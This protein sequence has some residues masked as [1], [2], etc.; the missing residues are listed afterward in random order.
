MT[1]KSAVSFTDEHHAFAKEMVER[2]DFASVS[3]VVAA[4]LQRLRE[5]EKERHIALEAMAEEVRRRA[6]APDEDFVEHRTGDFAK[7]LQD[8]LAARK[9]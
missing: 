7:I 8:R 5:E 2:G 6:Q 1:I 3:A 4:G 9:R